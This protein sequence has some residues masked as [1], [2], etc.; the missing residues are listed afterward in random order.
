[1]QRPHRK[2]NF[3]AR[4]Y[5]PQAMFALRGSYLI[6]GQLPC[7]PGLLGSTCVPNVRKPQSLSTHC[8]V[9]QYWLLP[10]NSV[11]NIQ[12]AGCRDWRSHLVAG[13][14][15][16][17]AVVGMTCL[18]HAVEQQNDLQQKYRGSC[19]LHIRGCAS[20][21]RYEKTTITTFRCIFFG[22]CTVV[23]KL[24]VLFWLGF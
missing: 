22:D 23:S 9:F 4:A 13:V 2:F 14:Q 19:C 17:L 24:T 5:I 8:S 7:R 3:Y 1:M 21:I 11:P 6:A 12:H 16:Y 20:T 18:N 15:E 10:P